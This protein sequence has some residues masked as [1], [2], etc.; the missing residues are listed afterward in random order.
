MPRPASVDVVASLFAA[1][2]TKAGLLIS[3]LLKCSGFSWGRLQQRC[4]TTEFTF[5]LPTVPERTTVNLNGVLYSI[6]LVADL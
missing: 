1:T 5:L 2:A 4:I 6:S 3:I